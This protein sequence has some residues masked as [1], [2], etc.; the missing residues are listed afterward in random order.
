MDPRD[1]K[2]FPRKTGFRHVQ[3]PFKAGFTVNSFSKHMVA[4]ALLARKK[5]LG[6][7][8]IQVTCHFRSAL[9]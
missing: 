1:Y 9:I 4:I 8:M 3:V 5:A 2:C 7:Q 6:S